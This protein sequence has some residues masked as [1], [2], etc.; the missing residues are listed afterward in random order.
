[1]GWLAAIYDDSLHFMITCYICIWRWSQQS[2]GNINVC[3][4][5]IA[6]NLWFRHLTYGPDFKKLGGKGQPLEMEFLSVK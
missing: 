3:T 6:F 1:M 5:A 2:N 4:D